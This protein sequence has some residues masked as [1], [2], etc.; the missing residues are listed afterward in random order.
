MGS[1]W[2]IRNVFVPCRPNRNRRNFVRFVHKHFN[3]FFKLAPLTSGTFTLLIM[4]SLLN[5]GAFSAQVLSEI[6]EGI[7]VLLGLFVF[8][9]Y[10]IGKVTSL[11]K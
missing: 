5:A 11:G 7:F 4:E 10:Y 2:V 6:S 9:M 8:Q 3:K 1:P